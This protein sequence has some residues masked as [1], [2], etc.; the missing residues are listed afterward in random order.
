LLLLTR[1]LARVLILLARV[2]VA[3]SGAPLLNA[4]T[5]QPPRRRSVAREHSSGAVLMW[6]GLV[7]AATREQRR[8]L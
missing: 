1:F 8:N 3:H 6:R 2:L 4:T 5:N 7:A